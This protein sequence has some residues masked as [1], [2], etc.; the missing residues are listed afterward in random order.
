MYKNVSILVLMLIIISISLVS[1]ATVYRVSNVSGINVGSGFTSISAAQTAALAG[2]TLLVE[3]SVQNYGSITLTKK[4]ILIGT[5][6]FLSGNSQTQANL[7]TSKLIGLVFNSGCSGSIVCGFEING[8]VD[9]NIGNITV[10]RNIVNGNIVVYG[11]SSGINQ[12]QIIQ[13]YIN[14]SVNGYSYNNYNINNLNILNNYI[15]N[16]SNLYSNTQ[17]KM[18][19]NIFKANISSYNFI[20][21]NNIFY[22]LT[23]QIDS[24]TN[25]F[26]NNISNSNFIPFNNNNKRNISMTNVFVSSIGNSTDGQY[27]LSATSPAKL[28]GNDSLDCGMFGGLD[29]YVLS[30]IP[31]IPAIYELN[32]PINGTATTNGMNVTI[33]AKS[34]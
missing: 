8:N 11:N 13:N 6:Y 30:G 29:P 26:F 32:V 33:K 15:N 25:T 2:D 27:Q 24:I 9:I 16:N 20:Y 18:A 7:A 3:G 21:Q 28:A 4:L 17:G 1:K 31:E 5:G 23:T 12:V 34:H 14:G 19:N 10:K 22:S